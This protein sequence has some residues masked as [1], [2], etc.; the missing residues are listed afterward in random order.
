MGNT[1][2][3]FSMSIFQIYSVSASG[4]LSLSAQLYDMRSGVAMLMVH[5]C[6]IFSS[7]G[8]DCGIDKEEK[9]M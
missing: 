8:L 6:N 9:I 7:S 4:L 1:D 5:N 3:T 2:A